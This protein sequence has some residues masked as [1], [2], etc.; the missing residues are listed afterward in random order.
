MK[1]HTRWYMQ[2]VGVDCCCAY[3]TGWIV[4]SSVVKFYVRHRERK[5]AEYYNN[6]RNFISLNYNQHF[7]N[8]KP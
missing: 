6:I 4:T 8:F 7:R 2:H 1:Q 5:F 3:I